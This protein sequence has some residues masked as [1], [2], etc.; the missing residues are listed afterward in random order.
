M[1][2]T[3]VKVRVWPSWVVHDHVDLARG[4]LGPGRKPV[5]VD[6]EIAAPLTS[7]KKREE[8]KK[9]KQPA[10]NGDSG[11]RRIPFRG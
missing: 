11:L 7:R 9:E 5:E 1:T 2:L 6:P 3:P 10:A 4:R 8:R